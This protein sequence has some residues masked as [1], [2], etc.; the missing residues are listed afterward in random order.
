MHVCSI[1]AAAAANYGDSTATPAVE[2]EVL[3]VRS[4]VQNHRSVLEQISVANQSGIRQR[5]RPVFVH[6]P[7]HPQEQ[8][9]NRQLQLRAQEAAQVRQG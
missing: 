5:T 9:Q 7:H 2:A 4:Q 8:G 6:S 3:L 1:R